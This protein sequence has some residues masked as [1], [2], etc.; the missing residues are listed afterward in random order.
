M[1]IW[2]TQWICNNDKERVQNIS[3][4]ERMYLHACNAPFSRTIKSFSEKAMLTMVQSTCSTNYRYYTVP[5]MVYVHSAS[6]HILF[7][8]SKGFGLLKTGHWTVSRFFEIRCLVSGGTRARIRV[9]SS[10]VY[11]VDVLSTCIVRARE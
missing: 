1:D 6:L 11:L 8:S 10:T 9:H 3:A 2:L 5:T 7:P 4:Y